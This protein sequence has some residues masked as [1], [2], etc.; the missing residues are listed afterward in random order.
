MKLPALLFALVTGA[1]LAL[2]AVA[3]WSATYAVAYGAVVLMAAMIAATFLWLWVKRATPLALGMA[4]SWAG[5]ASVLG[6]W[7][8]WRATGQPDAM[9]QN[10]ALFAFVALYLV[11]A[12]LHFHVIER[13]MDLRPGSFAVPVIGAIALSALAALVM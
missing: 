4:F 7:W 12:T 11:G 9:S 1:L 5:T 8:I 10:A 13:S 6:W 2:H 3:G